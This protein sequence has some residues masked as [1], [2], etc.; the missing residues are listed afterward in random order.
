MSIDVNNE[1]GY[2]VDELELIALS[3]SVLDAM[4]VHP[5]RSCRWCWWTRP[6]WSTCT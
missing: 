2:D 4:R 1:S 6:R 5:P 3:R